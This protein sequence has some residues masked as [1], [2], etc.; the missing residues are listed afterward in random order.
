IQHVDVRHPPFVLIN[1][2]QY[3]RDIRF[4]PGVVPYGFP[5][6]LPGACRP[7]PF[8]EL[9]SNAVLAGGEIS[10]TR[11]FEAVSPV[12][13]QLVDQQRAVG[14]NKGFFVEENILVGL[15]EILERHAVSHG[16]LPLIRNEWDL[17]DLRMSDLVPEMDECSGPGESAAHIDVPV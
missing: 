9:V 11:S 15:D 2:L 17:I 13:F 8:L 5:E 7:R 3:V 14:P 4:I 1:P 12:G 16:E 10:T 6:A